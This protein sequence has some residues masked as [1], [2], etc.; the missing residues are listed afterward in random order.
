LS[1]S[2]VEFRELCRYAQK[3]GGS[4]VFYDKF[5][6]L[7]SKKGVKPTPAA[8]AA[9]ISKSLVTKWKTDRIEIPSP[10]VLSKLSKYFN[11]PVSELLGED[12]ENENSP[13]EY[14]LTEGEK[15]LI[16][17]FRLIPEEQQRH[18]LEMGRAFA[19]SLRKG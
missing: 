8:T 15:Q 11:I 1:T 5:L 18:F 13:S 16:E 4:I 2:F 17:L 12:A 6:E 7:C 9:G 19:N 3:Y 10:E 14:E